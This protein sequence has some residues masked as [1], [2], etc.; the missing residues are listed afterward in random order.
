MKQSGLPL[1]VTLRDLAVLRASEVD[2]SK[3]LAPQEASPDDEQLERSLE[4][5]REAR[6]A[7]KLANNGSIERQGTRIDEIRA[8]GEQVLEAL[9]NPDTKSSWWVDKIDTSASGSLRLGSRFYGVTI[10]IVPGLRL[11]SSTQHWC[12]KCSRAELN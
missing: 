12:L 11:F 2:L 1:S 9:E 10:Y 4:F 5:S 7:L 6:K 3:V 8:L